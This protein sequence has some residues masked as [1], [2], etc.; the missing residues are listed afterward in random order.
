[1]LN[2]SLNIF[3]IIKENNIIIL[4]FDKQ[5]VLQK[6]RQICRFKLEEK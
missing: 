6:K 4:F 1:M 3:I 5:R 2:E